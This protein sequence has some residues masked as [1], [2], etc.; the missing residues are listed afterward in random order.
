MHQ[1]VVMADLANLVVVVT[2]G[3]QHQKLIGFLGLKIILFIVGEKMTEKV[4]SDKYLSTIILTMAILN[5]LS[6]LIL[7]Q[8]IVTGI[9]PQIKLITTIGTIWEHLQLLLQI[10]LFIVGETMTEKVQLDK[11][12]STI[13]PTMVILNIL[14]QL[15]QVQIVVTGIFPQ[16]KLITTIGTIWELNHNNLNTQWHRQLFING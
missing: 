9:F 6:Q 16:I 12:S 4:Q 10:M 1:I 15:I 13:I 5:I 7:V 2:S 14:S 3:Q 11:Y 8:M